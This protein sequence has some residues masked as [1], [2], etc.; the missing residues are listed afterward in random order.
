MVGRFVSDKIITLT[1]HENIIRSSP[2]QEA[3]K[4]LLDRVS[5]QLQNGNS[6]A[7]EKMLMTI[8]QHNVSAAK[9]VSLEIRNKLSENSEQG[10]KF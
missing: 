6:T 8:E 4:L 1:D 9:A 10:S 7:F 2:P 5:L 3:A